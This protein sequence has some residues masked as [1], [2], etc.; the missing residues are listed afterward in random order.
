MIIGDALASVTDLSA[1]GLGR[2]GLDKG[3]HIGVERLAVAFLLFP[4]V[5]SCPVVYYYFAGGFLYHS[6]Y[7]ISRT[8]S[9]VRPASICA[10]H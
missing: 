8:V 7:Y 6:F 1:T 2:R 4:D 3:R 10:G 9:S 5:F